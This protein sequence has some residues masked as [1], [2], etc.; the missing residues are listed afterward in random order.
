MT[1]HLFLLN[2]VSDS[3][4]TN[5]EDSLLERV[6]SISKPTLLKNSSQSKPT[7][8]KLHLHAIHM[9]L[10]SKGLGQLAGRPLCKPCPDKGDPSKS[11]GHL[12]DL[13][14]KTL[15][16]RDGFQIPFMKDSFA[17]VRGGLS[18]ESFMSTSLHC[19]RD[20]LHLHYWRNDSETR[21][22]GRSS[23]VSRS[24]VLQYRSRSE[25]ET[26]RFVA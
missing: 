2:K 5:R 26:E 1:R 21:K 3:S 9:V 25:T 12:V 7:A 13:N 15:L 10:N 17:I 6:L 22:K 16:P 18:R 14:A 24:S 8:W 20:I 4:V 11:P 19:H 23:C